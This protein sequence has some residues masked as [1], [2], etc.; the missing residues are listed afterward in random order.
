MSCPAVGYL[1]ALVLFGPSTGDD[2]HLWCCP[3][4]PRPTPLW[5]RR[6]PLGCWVVW[7]LVVEPA[8]TPSSCL[9]RQLMASSSWMPLLGASVGQWTR[10]PLIRWCRCFFDIRDPGPP[11]SP[12]QGL[13]T[14]QL[15]PSARPLAVPSRWRPSMNW[16]GGASHASP[17]C[18]AVVICCVFCVWRLFFQAHAVPRSPQS[19]SN[20]SWKFPGACC[21]AW[22]PSCRC[23]SWR[24]SPCGHF[25]CLV[26]GTVLR[27][28][29]TP[30]GGCE[31]QETFPGGP[32]LRP[33][34]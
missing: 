10:G 20:A 8:W 16:L 25:C 13:G 27:G 34:A 18:F 24:F 31:A 17:P 4:F 12:K 22:S 7:A 28:G 15:A 11:P 1:S 29:G 3:L 14:F 33:F 5:A 26:C 21:T 6:F 9:L 2:I 30:R 23:T 32:E 19:R